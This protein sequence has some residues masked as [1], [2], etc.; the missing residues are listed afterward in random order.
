M[1]I[2][3]QPVRLA[4]NGAGWSPAPIRP[5]ALPPAYRPAL[6]QQQAAL[7]PT[8]GGGAPAAAVAAAKPPLIDSALV[9][10]AF[11]VLTVTTTGILAWGAT[12]PGWEKIHPGKPKPRP[13]VWVYVFGILSGGFAMKTLFD[14]SRIRQR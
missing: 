2:V 7:A 4:G 11:D 3:I 9:A 10:T 6:A 14:L 12:Y 13:S 5:P 8:G 1:S